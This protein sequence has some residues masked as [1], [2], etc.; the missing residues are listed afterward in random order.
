MDNMRFDA[1][2][3]SLGAGR[4]RREVI[5]GIGGAVAGAIGLSVLGE[6]GVSARGNSACAQYCADVFGAD[7]PEAGACTREAAHGAG[8]CFE[9]GPAAPAGSRTICGQT[10]CGPDE[11][12]RGGTTCAPRQGSCAARADI[13]LQGILESTYC[14]DLPEIC[15]CLTT[16]AGATFCGSTNIV[17]SACVTDADCA[18]VT[19]PNSACVGY[20]GPACGCPAGPNAC[21]SPCTAPM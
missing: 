1:L 18:S 10:C 5:R 13:C 7:T 20:A 21:V 15:M 17:C 8:P 11:I 16:T 2:A 6:A 12:C 9:C 3:R 19:G 14:H 4:S